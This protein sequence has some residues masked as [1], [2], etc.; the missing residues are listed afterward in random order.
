[1]NRSV[2]VIQAR[3]SSEGGN[4]GLASQGCA[5]AGNS[6]L[7]GVIGFGTPAANDSRS[8]SI[9]AMV[10]TMPSS[11]VVDS[12]IST[13]PSPFQDGMHVSESGEPIG[14]SANDA[15][16][17]GDD[18][19][20]AKDGD[21]ASE[22]WEYMPVLLPRGLVDGSS[23]SLSS[24]AVLDDRHSREVE[25]VRAGNR[26]GGVGRFITGLLPDFRGRKM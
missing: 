1:M 10:N 22:R 7:A 11:Q 4:D 12:A 19:E 6:S 25:E 15:Q 5:S 13:M 21:S 2:Q 17:S 16:G 26:V 24:H 20:H 9:T 14:S 23:L 8:G 3:G 18:I